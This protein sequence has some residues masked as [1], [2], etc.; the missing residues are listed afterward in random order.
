[1]KNAKLA[2]GVVCAA[3]LLFGMAPAALAQ[4]NGTGS[5]TGPAA[6]GNVTPNTAPSQQ[7]QTA[8]GSGQNTGTGAAGVAAKPNTES[9]PQVKTP[10]NGQQQQ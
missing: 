5:T 2:G 10:G 3:L 6:G 9:G 1:M 7:K 8:A 4:N